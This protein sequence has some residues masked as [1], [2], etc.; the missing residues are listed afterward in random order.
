MNEILENIVNCNISVVNPVENRAGFGTILLVGNGPLLEGNSLKSVDM[1]SSLAEVQ[2]AGWGEDSKM[3]QAARA[4][5]LQKSKPKII[6]IAVRQKGGSK[7]ETEE[8]TETVKRA[9]G[10]EGW[11]G[12]SLIDADAANGDYD[13]VADLIENTEKIFAFSVQDMKNPITNNSYMR[14]FGM[15]SENEYAHIAWMAKAFSFHPGSETWAFKTLFEIEPSV[16]SS[17]Q[18]RDLEGEN[19]NYY[20]NCAGK[21][22]TKNGKM[23]GGEWIDIIRFRDWLKNQM[24]L[25]ITQLFI[26]S[27]MVPYTVSGIVLVEN[28]MKAVLQSGQKTGGIAETEYDE[29]DTPVYG[30]TVTV[31]KDALEYQFTARLSG[32][33]HVIELQGNLI[34]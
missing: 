22:I 20:I 31:S 4:A 2:D 10:T 28:L 23:I 16:L 9:L 12:I 30:Y 3:Y 17:R 7:A 19:L 34:F 26:K 33:I 14:T 6:Y 21:D 29:E 18:R 1:Y 24:Q 13:K 8:V 15:Y 32:A 25:K 11:Y 5:F 27:P